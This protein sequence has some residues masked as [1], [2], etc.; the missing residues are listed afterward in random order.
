MA[1]GHGVTRPGRSI[2][3]LRVGVDAAIQAVATHEG[4]V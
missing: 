2:R 1:H 3:P 4:P